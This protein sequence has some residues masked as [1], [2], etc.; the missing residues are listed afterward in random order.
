MVL[1]HAVGQLVKLLHSYLHIILH[2]KHF[3]ELYD[4]QKPRNAQKYISILLFLNG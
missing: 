3:K 2:L 4:S 1:P